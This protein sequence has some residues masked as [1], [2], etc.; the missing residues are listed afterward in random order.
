MVKIEHGHKFI[1][2]LAVVIF[3]M[4]GACQIAP[5]VHAQGSPQTPDTII[6]I[7]SNFKLVNLY[8]KALD[9]N[10]TIHI[11]IPGASNNS[12]YYYSIRV[13]NNITNGSMNN[14]LAQSYLVNVSRIGIIEIMLDNQ[15]RLLWTNIRIMAGVTQTQIDNGASPFTIS[16]LPSQWTSKEWRIFYAMITSALICSF[17]AYRLVTSYRKARGVIEVR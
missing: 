5:R 14:Y 17:I 7:D 3:L 4:S 9:K 8:E 2:L 16:L 6:L 13:D 10:F 12:T 1:C 11:F 15:S